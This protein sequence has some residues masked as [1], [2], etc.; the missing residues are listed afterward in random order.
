MS[1]LYDTIKNIFF[2][3]DPEDM[4]DLAVKVGEEHFL[5]WSN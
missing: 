4:R 2:L 5:R 3:K 1:L